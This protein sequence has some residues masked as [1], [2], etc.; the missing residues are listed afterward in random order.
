MLCR[1]ECL[2]RLLLG[3]LV[4]VRG[5]QLIEVVIG[6]ELALDR[7]AGRPEY[8][9]APTA[10][11]ALVDAGDLERRQSQGVRPVV[12]ILLGLLE[13]HDEIG[14]LDDCVGILVA[15]HGFGRLRDARQ[16][17]AELT[18][19][20]GESAEIVEY[21]GVLEQRLHFL[22]IQPCP[23]SL[24]EV[25]VHD[26][27]HRLAER[28][29]REDEHGVGHV[30]EVQ[31]DGAG[32]EVD[33]G[34]VVEE[35]RVAADEALI[36]QG[37]ILRHRLG[38]A[39]Q[40]LVEVLEDRLAAPLHVVAAE[41]VLDA[42]LDDGALLLGEYGHG[43]VGRGRR[44]RDHGIGLE[45]NLRAEILGFAAL[46]HAER[47]QVRVEADTERGIGAPRMLDEQ[48]VLAGTV[49]DDNLVVRLR[50]Q[51]ALNL[52]LGEESL[53]RSRLAG[54]EA[55]GTCQVGSVAE[56]EVVRQLVLVVPAT[57]LLLE[58]LGGERDEDARL[59]RG[60]R[61]GNLDVVEAEGQNRVQTLALAVLEGLHLHARGR[62]D[63]EDLEYLL[64]QLLGGLRP[65]V[66]KA[67]EH[68]E[69][70]LLALELRQQILGL[71]AGVSQLRG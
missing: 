12:A 46:V 11:G 1:I 37:D 26:V 62:R 32:R 45:S 59:R 15:D 33:V 47:V 36:A 16:V 54:D 27:S 39:L 41:D 58:L 52:V 63:V 13:Q 49:E 7:H 9:K 60:E 24:V 31:S 5:E 28:D 19:L 51:R 35:V 2:S 53:A 65:R 3:P 44:L 20:V 25:A 30:L 23:A 38:L 22:D 67:G 71:L 55:D 34:L 10:G 6:R 14:V 40:L 21:R 64:G 69:V 43:L 8:E 18:A 29:Q 50:E 17:H 48:L 42:A 4:R 68:E 66:D 61:A 57:A 56:H 70:L